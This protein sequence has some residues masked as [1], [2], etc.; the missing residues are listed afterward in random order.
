[1]QTQEV[2]IKRNLKIVLKA[3]A[4]MLDEVVVVAYGAAK[5]S[6]LTGSVE[7]VKADQLS[8][9][10]VNSV[11][12][13][14]QGKAAG[15]Q[16]TAATGRPGASANIKIR[17]TSSISAG[18][19]P[20]FVIDGVPVSSADFAALN[21]NDIEYMSVLKD[22]SA[23]AIYGSRGSNGV[24]LITTK[25]GQSGKTTIDLKAIFGISTRTLSDSDFT[26]MNAQEKLTYERQL[27]IGRGSSGGAN[28]GA[29]TDAEI[30]AAKNTNWADEIFRTGTTQSY[31]LNVAGGT[32]ATRFYLSGQYFDQDAIVPGSYLRRSTLRAN[33]DHCV[34]M[35][36][37]M[38]GV[39]KNI[40]VVAAGPFQ[41]AMINPVITKKS[42]AFQTEEGCLSLEGVRPCT[43]Y[44]EIEVD[45][46]DQGFKKQH[47][48]YSGWT[49][50]I[51][52][53]E[54]DHCNGIVI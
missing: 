53:H 14:L 2:A 30:A 11:D 46:L 4:A 42:G 39:K 3:D 35:A 5:K 7:I 26:M 12:Q 1:M 17:G 24:I 18:S 38:I 33:L 51:I 20:L 34:G 13:A 48:K 16:V 28:G 49:A 44:Q 21:S 37:N 23:T 10:P 19:D 29:M 52:Q 15:V 8:K 9:V 45:Y 41:F 54:I 6:S 43:R 22:A 40:I 47:G 50:Q 36:A 32:D 31:E 25:K 27:G